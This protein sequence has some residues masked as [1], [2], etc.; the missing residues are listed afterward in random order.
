[1]FL[2]KKFYFISVLTSELSKKLMREQ[3]R[4][5]MFQLEGDI[6]DLEV[7]QTTA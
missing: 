5:R 4:Y 7:R 3:E 6:A 1:M 2:Y